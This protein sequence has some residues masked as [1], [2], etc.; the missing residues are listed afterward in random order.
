MPANW[1]RGGAVA[2]AALFIAAAPFALRSYHN[3]DV[4]NARVNQVGIFQKKVDGVHN[5]YEFEREKGRTPA[6][7]LGTQ[8]RYSLETVF[9]TKDQWNFYGADV[10]LIG[11]GVLPVLAIGL[12]W[13]VWRIREPR[14]FLLI[15]MLFAPIVTGGVFTI[16]DRLIP[17][18]SSRLLAI[19][20]AVS[21]LVGVGAE[22]VGVL[23]SRRGAQQLMV[24]L[25]V[26]VALSVASLDYY[27]RLYDSVGYSDVTTREIQ[28][29]DEDVRRRVPEGT[30]V[31]FVQNERWNLG[32][33]RLDFALRKYRV[34]EVAKDGDLVR[35]HNPENVEPPPGPVAM[36]MVG[37]ASQELPEVMAACPGGRP[38]RLPIQPVPEF[39]RAIYIVDLPTSLDRADATT[40]HPCLKPAP[41]PAAGSLR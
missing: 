12:A 28:Q 34:L 32:H 5:W 7:I 29:F 17:A 1:I 36:L 13:C 4:F 18:S 14:Y 24:A 9:L 2:L 6:E 35:I 3:P 38:T 40:V 19:I 27:F 20:P 33:P 21:A 11:T 30:E 41:T 39:G 22:R 10:P 26:V 8:L 23:A 31:H 25:A 16:P 15:V 37:S